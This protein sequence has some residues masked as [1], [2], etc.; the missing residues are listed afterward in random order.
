MGLPSLEINLAPK[1]GFSS[2]SCD[3]RKLRRSASEIVI[4]ILSPEGERSCGL[5]VLRLRSRHS[6]LDC[7]HRLARIGGNEEGLGA[8][9]RCGGGLEARTVEDDQQLRMSL[10]QSLRKA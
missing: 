4:E 9:G 7:R 10:V 5:L 8:H 1:T 3:C 6:R 2:R